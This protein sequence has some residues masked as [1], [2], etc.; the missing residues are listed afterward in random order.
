MQK[1]Y[2]GEPEDFTARM[3][4]ADLGPFELELVQPL[5]GQSIWA[6]FLREH[7]EGLHHIRFNVPD[8]QPVIEYL[9]GHGIGVTQMGS[10]LRPGTTWVNFDTEEKVGFTIEIMNALAGTDGRT[11]HITDGKVQV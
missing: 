2:Y 3:A 1:V 11:P 4:F 9:A 5:S 10:G 7:G 8:V 6:D